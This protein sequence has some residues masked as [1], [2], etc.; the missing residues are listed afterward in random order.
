M[1][2]NAVLNDEM[3][4]LDFHV[5]SVAIDDRD[6]SIGRVAAERNPGVIVV[7]HAEGLIFRV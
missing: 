7:L 6:R 1:R 5:E 2:P 3:P 4:S